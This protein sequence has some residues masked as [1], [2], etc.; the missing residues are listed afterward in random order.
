MREFLMVSLIAFALTQSACASTP[1][2]Q[3]AEAPQTVRGGDAS[4]GNLRIGPTTV[5]GTPVAGGAGAEAPYLLRYATFRPQGGN[6]S[7]VTRG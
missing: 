5:K 7:I 3:R 6:R 1:S 2:T 4:L